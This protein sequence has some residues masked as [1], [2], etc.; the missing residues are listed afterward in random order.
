MKVCD[1]CLSENCSE[2]KV[3]I[4]KA[5]ERRGK[6]ID[7]DVISVP[8]DLCEKCLTNFLRQVGDFTRKVREDSREQRKHNA[9]EKLERLNA[10]NP[11]SD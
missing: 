2:V 5:D 1:I 4:V 11:P 3:T 10:G 7:R 9:T 8:F 6:I